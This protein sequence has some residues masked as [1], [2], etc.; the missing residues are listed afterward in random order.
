MYIFFAESLKQ[1]RLLYTTPCIEQNIF[2]ILYLSQLFL[3]E[4]YYGNGY[5]FLFKTL[6]PHWNRIRVQINRIP[7][8]TVNILC[9]EP[10]EYVPGRESDDYSQKRGHQ[11][12]NLYQGTVLGQLTVL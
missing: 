11:Q 6:E 5:M 9:Q 3:S 7:V 8:P 4:K 12:R 10:L 2:I 1:S